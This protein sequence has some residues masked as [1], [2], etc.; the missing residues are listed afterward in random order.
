MQSVHYS[1]K[2]D[3]FLFRKYQDQTMTANGSTSVNVYPQEDANKNPV[4]PN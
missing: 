1:E 2:E 4:R 3:K